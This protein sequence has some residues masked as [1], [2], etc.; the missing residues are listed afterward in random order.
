M[1]GY[2]EYQYHILP[3]GCVYVC[4]L[5]V[6]R[7]GLKNST[8]FSLYPISSKNTYPK[9][10]LSPPRS[11]HHYTKLS[12]FGSKRSGWLVPYRHPTTT[13]THYTNHIFL[14]ITPWSHYKTWK[15]MICNRY[16]Y[17]DCQQITLWISVGAQETGT[18]WSEFQ[19]TTNPPTQ[20]K[21]LCTIGHMYCIHRA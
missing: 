21:Q 10:S 18:H 19:Q 2:E 17:Y 16:L 1:A 5:L 15:L 7:L 6:G 8:S 14:P 4:T 12:P 3:I 9:V 20:L 13:G 11:T